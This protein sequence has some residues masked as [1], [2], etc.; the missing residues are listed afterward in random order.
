LEVS[1][2]ANPVATKPA[3]HAEVTTME[4]RRADFFISILMTIYEVRDSDPLF[5]YENPL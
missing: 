4:R 5:D 3:R 1:A 2:G